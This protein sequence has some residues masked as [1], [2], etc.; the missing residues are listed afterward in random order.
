MKH[1]RLIECIELAKS[2]TTSVYRQ[3]D[4]SG[5]LG[6]IETMSGKLEDEFYV[7]GKSYG[8]YGD[9]VPIISGKKHRHIAEENVLVFENNDRDVN[10][11]YH[12]TVPYILNM[13]YGIEVIKNK[14][15]IGGDLVT[16]ENLYKWNCIAT[17]LISERLNVKYI[18]EKY[19]NTNNFIAL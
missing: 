14:V 17:Y 6:H 5:Y 2:N 3:F 16:A 9:S 4:F 7:I 11:H 15:F 8:F 13:E 12:I 18:F 19:L 1:N 10:F